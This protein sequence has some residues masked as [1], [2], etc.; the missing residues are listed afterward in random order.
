MMISDWNI[1][2]ITYMMSIL[3]C[4]LLFDSLYF[5]LCIHYLFD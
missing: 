2:D 1:I 4:H 5:I 3:Y